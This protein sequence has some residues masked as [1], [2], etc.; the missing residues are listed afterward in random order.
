MFIQDAITNITSSDIWK[1]SNSVIFITWDQSEVDF[2]KS[3]DSWQF[4]TAGPDSLNLSVGTKLLPAEGIYG[5]GPMPL[6]ALWSKKPNNHVVYSEKSNHLFT[7][8]TQSMEFD[9]FGIHNRRNTN[10]NL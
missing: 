2:K 6:I 1:N 3:T 4:V 5:G 9:L 7:L 8:Y 10:Q